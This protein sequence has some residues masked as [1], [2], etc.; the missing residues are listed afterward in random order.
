MT[1][2]SWISG[3]TVGKTKLDAM[4][5]DVPHI[6]LMGSAFGGAGDVMVLDGNT[7]EPAAA[8]FSWDLGLCLDRYLAIVYSA[9]TDATPDVL[10][11]LVIFGQRIPWFHDSWMTGGLEARVRI[12]DLEN[13]EAG[14]IPMTDLSGF[15]VTFQL[16]GWRAGGSAL[17][18][19]TLDL[20]S[21]D[22]ADF[23]E[24]LANFNHVGA[25]DQIGARIDGVL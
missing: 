11:W 22:T 14:N 9:T 24:Y 4:E 19:K 7:S 10:G 5:N 6:K 17:R 8:D 25:Q 23:E 21:S 15:P 12:I 1:R 20:F 2:Q 16:K 3:E 18:I 13:V